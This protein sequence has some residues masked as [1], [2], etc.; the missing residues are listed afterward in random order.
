MP[1]L[2]ELQRIRHGFGAGDGGARRLTGQGD[3]D[4]APGLPG[5]RAGGASMGNLVRLELKLR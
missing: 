2:Y 1:S 3:I 4:P 5:Y